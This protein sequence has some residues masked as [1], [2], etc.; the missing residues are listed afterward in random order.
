MGQG[1]QQSARCQGG[2]QRRRRAPAGVALARR[3]QLLPGQA[4]LW[5]C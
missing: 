3:P 4:Y 2:E 1:S 5:R